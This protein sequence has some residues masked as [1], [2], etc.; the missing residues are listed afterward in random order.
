[1]DLPS[2]RNNSFCCPRYCCHLLLNWVSEIDGVSLTLENTQMMCGEV[3]THLVWF[4]LGSKF[5][6]PCGAGQLNPGVLSPGN[7]YHTTRLRTKV[8]NSFP[9]LPCSLSPSYISCDDWV[10]LYF[11]KYWMRAH[12]MLFLQFSSLPILSFPFTWH[13]NRRL[14]IFLAGRKSIEHAKM[15]VFSLCFC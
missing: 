7:C 3:G 15:N 9:L 12:V 8:R 13:W 11:F 2:P 4:L 6:D 5:T 1:M 10:K 14:C